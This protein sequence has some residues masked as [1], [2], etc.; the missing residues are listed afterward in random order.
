MGVETVLKETILSL[1][2]AQT[3]RDQYIF[4]ATLVYEKYGNFN[5]SL[6]TAADYE[7]TLRLHSGF[8]PSSSSIPGGTDADMKKALF[9]FQLFERTEESWH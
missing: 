3:G 1:L 2:L 4:C 9:F 5:L 6:G 7:L 8:F